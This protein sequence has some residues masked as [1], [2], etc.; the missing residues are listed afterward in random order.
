MSSSNSL[1]AARRRR[2]APPQQSRATQQQRQRQPPAQQ[3]QQQQGQPRAQPIRTTPMQ[4]LTSHEQRLN[5][6]E[7]QFPQAINNINDNINVLTESFQT[8]Q[9]ARDFSPDIDE[10]ANRVESLENVNKLREEEPEEDL[11][12]FR[13]KVKSME[14]QLLDVKTLLIK[15]QNF[16]METNL[17]LLKY[18][19]GMDAQLALQI[20]ENNKTAVNE[21]NSSENANNKNPVLVVEEEMVL[22][23]NDHDGATS[24][25]IG[26]K[27]REQVENVLQEQA[28]EQAQ[29]QEQ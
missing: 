2:A 19:N 1:A 16:A 25:D 29:T 22:E 28:Q 24:V 14:K 27:I 20:Q 5:R 17:T 15:V 7:T 21:S 26:T 9:P 11:E 4:A 6:M 13:N 3:Q 23:P 12:Y 18:K 10:L 8:F